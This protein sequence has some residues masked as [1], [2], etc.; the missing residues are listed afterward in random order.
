MGNRD[1]VGRHHWTVIWDWAS[2]SDIHLPAYIT[3]YNLPPCTLPLLCE[4][5]AAG[6]VAAG[7][8]RMRQ[9]CMPGLIISALL[10]SRTAGCIYFAS[11]FL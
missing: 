9:H 3:S 7:E 5:T 2:E 4:D 8:I 6:L 10:I 11:H 1:S